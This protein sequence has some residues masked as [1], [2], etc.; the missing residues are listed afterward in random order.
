MKVL[1]IILPVA[2][3]LTCVNLA[4]ADGAPDPR[5][6]LGGGGSCASF[7]QTS[8]T[9]SFH[10]TT[11]GCLVDFTNDITN[12]DEGVTLN[13]LVVNVTSA[14][15]GPLTCDVSEGAPF[16]SG[17]TSSPTSCTFQNQILIESHVPAISDSGISPGETYSLTFDPNFGSFVD[18][19]LA[20]QVIATPEPSIIVL[21]CVG[22]VVLVLAGRKRISTAAI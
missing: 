6:T 13:L 19:T 14:F 1:R 7:D 17:T 5:I 3:F 20:Q 2:L 21:L 9:Q 8:L 15:S 16:N 11:L 18:I 22:L 10:I 12:D 4:F